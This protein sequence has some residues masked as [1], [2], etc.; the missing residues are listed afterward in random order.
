MRRPFS[1]VVALAALFGLVTPSAATIVDITYTGT[2]TSFTDGLGL[3]KGTVIKDGESFVASYVFNTSLG[4]EHRSST[5]NLSQ[6]VGYTNPLISATVNINGI[7]ISVP[8]TFDS[9]SQAQELPGRPQET[10]VLGSL[11]GVLPAIPQ[12]WQRSDFAESVSIGHSEYLSSQV[13]STTAIPLT[14]DGLL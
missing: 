6:N 5:N 1:G 3:F 9:F 13:E 12:L 10:F 4:Y 8:G 14:V 11:L 2:V 7:T